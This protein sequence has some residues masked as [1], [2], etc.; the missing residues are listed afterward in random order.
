MQRCPWGSFC[1][2][3]P[4]GSLRHR[5]VPRLPPAGSSGGSGSLRG[6]CP[7]PAA[8][9]PLREAITNLCL[10]RGVLV[11]GSACGDPCFHLRVAGHAGPLACACP[12]RWWDT[13]PHSFSL[14]CE[15]AG[16]HNRKSCFNPL[17]GSASS[18]VSQL[19]GAEQDMLERASVVKKRG[20]RISPISI[21]S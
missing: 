4:C 20:T 14:S 19:A 3:C 2:P 12:T 15:L 7:A 21:S 10:G 8:A 18:A 13:L 5:P 11:P 9:L 1:L 17:E 16:A 6:Q